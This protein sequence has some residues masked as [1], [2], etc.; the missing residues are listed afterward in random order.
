MFVLI[1]AVL[2]LT[3]YLSIGMI[4]ERNRYALVAHKRASLENNVEFY[5][6]AYDEAKANRD[7]INHM[8]YCYLNYPALSKQGC[9]SCTPEN[10]RSWRKYTLLMDE[11][12]KEKTRIP[13]PEISTGVIFAWPLWA[14]KNWLISGTV[15]NTN[16]YDPNLVNILEKELQIHQLTE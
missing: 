14:A 16:K 1:F 15:K 3:A 6:R 11:A 8:S 4:T 9:N 5:S 7:K 2:F 10:G 13:N 12:K